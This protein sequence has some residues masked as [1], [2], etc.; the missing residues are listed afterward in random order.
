MKDLNRTRDDPRRSGARILDTAEGVVIA[1]RGCTL[2]QAFIEIV[3]TAKK[4]NVA[5]VNLADALVAIVQK[6]STADLDADAVRAA[7]ETWGA[8]LD[9]H[10]R[11]G[12]WL[13]EPVQ[14]DD[15]SRVFD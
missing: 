1:L 8:L 11:D 14:D 13:E 2:N 12:A 15:D 10:R 5:P 9:G 6:Q 4:H 7:Q 3:N